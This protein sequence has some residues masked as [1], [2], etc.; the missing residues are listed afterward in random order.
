MAVVIV[1]DNYYYY[2]MRRSVDFVGKVADD[3]RD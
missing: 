1:D 2:E 3:I